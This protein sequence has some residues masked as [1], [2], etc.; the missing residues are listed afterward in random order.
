MMNGIMG[1]DMTRTHAAIA[2]FWVVVLGL[3]A[4]QFWS[5]PPPVKRTAGTAPRH[6]VTREYEGPVRKKKRAFVFRDVMVHQETP[7]QFSFTVTL[8]LQNTGEIA[9]KNV[10]VQI[11]PYRYGYKG[12]FDGEA[13]EKEDPLY[14]K[15]ETVTIASLKPGETKPINAVF[16]SDAGYFPNVTMEAW[17]VKYDEVPDA[18]EAAAEQARAKGEIR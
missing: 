17:D 4:W 18:D 9:F 16:K 13:V 5:A 11:R 6:A 10:R 7:D 12:Q 14:N 2:A 1:A 15:M 8:K 3:L